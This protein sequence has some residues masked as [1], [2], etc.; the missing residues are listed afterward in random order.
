MPSYESSMENLE[1]ARSVGR[2]PRPWRSREEAEMIRRYVF[3]W[4]TGRSKKPS[5]RDWARDLGISH[6]WLQRLV[7]EF[8]ADPGEMWRLQVAY[9]D[10]AFAQLSRAQEYTREMR[11]RAEFIVSIL[12]DGVAPRY[13]TTV[14]SS[15]TPGC[16]TSHK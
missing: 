16:A 3:L 15:C 7:R 14:N 6:T 11:E 5:G 12:Q 13:S 8:T 4:Y 9:G 1:K 10:P 2:P